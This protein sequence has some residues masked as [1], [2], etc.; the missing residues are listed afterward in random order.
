MEKINCCDL[1]G[2]KTFKDYLES[3]DYFLTNEGFTIVKCENCGLLFVNPRPTITEISKYYKSE[4]YI[5]HSTKQKGLLD[6]VYAI[7]RK[8]NHIKKYKLIKHYKNIGSIIDIGC[9]TGE[10]LDF[11]KKKGWDVTGVEPNEDARNF[12]VNTY[13]LNI[14][15]EKNIN[16]LPEK[17]YDIVTMWHV[18]EH[19]HDINERVFQLNRIL[20]N[21]GIAVIAV[22]NTNSDDASFYKTFWA[23]YDLPRHLY[24]FSSNTIKDLF[25]KKGFRFIET[26]PLGFDAF[27][28]SIISEKYKTGKKN[29]IKAFYHGLKSNIKA[30]RNNNEFSSLIYIFKKNDLK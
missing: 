23:G 21:E 14:F 10:F 4:N 7:I 27:Y 3:K 29:L 16:E 15:D 24:H 13:N 25:E 18:L 8:K 5:S 20:K 9:A 6:K 28:I 30:K 26:K 1:C 11:F 12:A 17:K 22:P 19:V 2:N